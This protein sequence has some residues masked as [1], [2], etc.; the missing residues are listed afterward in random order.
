VEK[1][2]KKEFEVSFSS[3]HCRNLNVKRVNGVM[4]HSCFSKTNYRKVMLMRLVIMETIHGA[5]LPV[6]QIVVTSRL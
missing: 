2:K 3:I 6:G 4:W 1:K 5:S